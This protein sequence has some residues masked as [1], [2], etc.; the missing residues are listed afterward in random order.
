MTLQKI[1]ALMVAG[2]LCVTMTGCGSS[3]KDAKDA[4]SHDKKT[5]KPVADTKEESKNDGESS[6]SETVEGDTAQFGQ[7]L[8]NKDGFSFTMS[9][10][11]EFQPSD[12]ALVGEGTPLKVH[13]TFKN[14]TDK[15]VETTFI[16]I[17]AQS[18]GKEAE[19]IY[20]AKNKLGELL[21]ETL[22]PGDSIE[23]DS[24]YAAADPN[25][26][27]LKIISLD[28]ATDEYHFVK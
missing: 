16:A 26:F 13:M 9:E 17:T 28:W 25:D 6:A 20:D 7:T 15:P 1:A 19:E 23:F 18:G 10:P 22:N 11:E 8:V 14:G 5:E 3:D 12:E 2:I 24:A 27:S 21:T 4:T